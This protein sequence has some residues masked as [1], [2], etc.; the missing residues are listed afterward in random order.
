MRVGRGRGWGWD[1]MDISGWGE[2]EDEDGSKGSAATTSLSDRPINY[3]KEG[4][5]LSPVLPE[6][7][8]PAPAPR[9]AV[10]F[11]LDMTREGSH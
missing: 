10:V 5:S 6:P 11:C 8:R 1:G 9:A 7:E 2:D 4:C 3:W